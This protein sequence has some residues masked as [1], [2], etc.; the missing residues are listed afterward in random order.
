MEECGLSSGPNCDLELPG[1]PPPVFF[2]ILVV[3]IFS[4]YTLVYLIPV[5]K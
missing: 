4:I 1:C 5:Q 3:L 2:P